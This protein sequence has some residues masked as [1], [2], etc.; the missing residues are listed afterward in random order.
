MEE[1]S[2]VRHITEIVLL[3]TIILHFMF[4][5]FIIVQNLF[6]FHTSLANTLIHIF[7]LLFLFPFQFDALCIFFR[8]V[9]P[10][11]SQRLNNHCRWKYFLL[12]ITLKHEF[13]T[14]PWSHQLYEMLLLLLTLFMYSKSNHHTH[15]HKKCNF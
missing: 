12:H 1:W 9:F 15:T 4:I 13:I 8:Y 3:K 6:P 14:M 11:F 2:L 10:A 5:L 7:L